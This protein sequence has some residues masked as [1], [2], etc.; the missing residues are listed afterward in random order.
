MRRDESTTPDELQRPKGNSLLENYDLHDEGEREF[1]RRIESIGLVVE[2]WGI[3]MRH[4]GGA[5]GIIYDSA[6]DFWVKTQEGELAAL[7]DVKTKSNPR[8]MGRFNLRHLY[9]YQEHAEREDVPV[10]VVMFQVDKQSGDIQ[11]EF[12]YQVLPGDEDSFI[13]SEDGS[14]K[15]FPDGNHAAMVKHSC[16]E[17]WGYLVSQMIMRVEEL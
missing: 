4:D 1:V 16:R 10:F 15:T 14:I 11:D 13:S 3:D 2:P 17:S 12:V 6:M 8:Y 7:V 5:E 9:D